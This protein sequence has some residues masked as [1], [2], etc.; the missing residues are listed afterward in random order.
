ML[1]FIRERN[2]SQSV[3]DT[4]DR[5][6]G[7]LGE[8][9]FRALFP[10]LLADNGSEF[11]NPLKLEFDSTGNRRTMVFYC[12]PN[13]PFQKPHVE[14]SHEFIRRILPKGTSFDNLEQSDVNLMMSHINSYPRK[15]LSNKA[16]FDLFT[17]IYGY[18]ILE[19][20]GMSKIPPNEILLKPALLKK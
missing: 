17:F 9:T 7:S 4:F 18:G 5:L 3:I 8:L 2:T 14:Y 20:L 11:S 10:L 12:D 16:P 15:K 13:A 1:A 6:Y 19:K